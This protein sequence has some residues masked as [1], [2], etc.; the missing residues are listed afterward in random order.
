MGSM[1]INHHQTGIIL[2]QY[3]YPVQLSDR[4]A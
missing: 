2:R 3:K 1:H 4:I